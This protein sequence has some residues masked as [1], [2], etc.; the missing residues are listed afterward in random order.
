MRSLE[1]T[2]GIG[3]RVDDLLLMNHEARYELVDVLKVSKS[4]MTRLLDD[5]TGWTI[6]NV[7]KAADHYGVSVEYLITGEPDNIDIVLS[8]KEID[9]GIMEK[10]V[11]IEK[12]SKVERRKLISRVLKYI[13]EIILVTED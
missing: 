9:R 5:K 12:L 8:G 4:F 2:Q 13:A 10:V 3:K 1:K 11:T 7:E 6:R